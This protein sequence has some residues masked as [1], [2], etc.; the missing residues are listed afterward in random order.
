MPQA[1]ADC[2]SRVRTDQPTCTFEPFSKR[3]MHYISRPRALGC[4]PA[5]LAQAFA[6]SPPIGALAARGAAQ[7]P[8]GRILSK[9]RVRTHAHV[10]AWLCSEQVQFGCPKRSRIGR[11]S[12]SPC[13]TRPRCHL[14]P[15]CCGANALVEG[16]VA[17]RANLIWT[18]ALQP[19]GLG[20]AHPGSCACGKSPYPY[21]ALRDRRPSPTATPAVAH[22]Q[23]ASQHHVP[24]LL[25]CRSAHM[26]T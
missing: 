14:R 7:S 2:T 20:R 16:G 1:A 4:A 19:L 24:A 25:R 17:V 21:A 15:T 26:H 11:H 23:Q 18:V 3:C 12:A 10:R 9:R 22:K 13:M 8:P 5:P 6:S